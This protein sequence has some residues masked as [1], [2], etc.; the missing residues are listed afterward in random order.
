MRGARPAAASAGRSKWGEIA[1]AKS[2]AA[3]FARRQYNRLRATN[4]RR[5]KVLPDQ[6][7]DMEGD[8][9]FHSWMHSK[10]D[11]EVMAS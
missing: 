1:G 7:G 4:N 9:V 3:G 11:Y 10:L 6:T 5:A 8:G 2:R